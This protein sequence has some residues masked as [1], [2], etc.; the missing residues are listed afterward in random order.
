LDELLSTSEL[1]K[2]LAVPVSTVYAWQSR[3]GGP[4]GYRV[5]RHTRYRSHEVLRWLEERRLAENT[6]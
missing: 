4:P 1:A 2:F 5:G 3:G 6:G